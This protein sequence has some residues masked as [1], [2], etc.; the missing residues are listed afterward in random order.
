MAV[1][2][3]LFLITS[4]HNQ[5]PKFMA[6]VQAVCQGHADNIFQ[7]S[8]VPFLLDLDE[9]VGVYL[10]VLGE[11]IG[12]S[13]QLRAPLP[14]SGI[15][16][17]ND[18]DYRTLLKAVVASNYWDGT[19]P[20]IYSIWAS[21]FAGDIFDVLV[22]DYQDM[23]M[24]IVILATNLSNVALALLINGYFDLRPA[25]VLMNGYFMPSVPGP[26]F[27][28]DVENATIQGWDEG[29]WVVPITV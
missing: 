18:D 1:S 20:G 21:V 28:F 12:A 29:A 22:M 25:G 17:L 7:L 16:E 11:F 10:D 19:V 3:Y 13:R 27:G 24:A 4:E 5:R 9:A 26:V 2:D 8:Q 15:T 6:V 14:P 23:S